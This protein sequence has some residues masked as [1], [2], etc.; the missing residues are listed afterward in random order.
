VTTYT[1]SAGGCAA[2]TTT[3]TESCNRNTDGTTCAATTCGG[4]GAC[5][6][7]STCANDGTQQRTCQQFQC[8]AG[9]CQQS[10]FTESQ[11]CSR[12]TNGSSCGTT[13]VGAWGPCSYA[14]TCANTGT[15]QRSVTTYTCSAGGCAAVTTTET[16]SCSRNTNGTT[17]AATTC[18]GFGACSYGSTCANDGTQQRTCQQFQCAAGTCQ[19]SSFTESQSCSRNTNGTTCGTTV[20]GGY[21]SCVLNNACD[22]TG[23]QFRTI[24]D[25]VCSGGGCA[26]VNTQQSQQCQGYVF[27]FFTGGP[28][29]QTICEGGGTSFSAS[30]QLNN[31]DAIQ[32]QVSSDGGSQWSNLSNSGVF[33]GVNS[34]TLSISGAPAWLNQYRF[35]PVILSACSPQ[36]V[37]GQAV[38]TVNTKPTSVSASA[39]PTVLCAGAQLN[40]SASASGA[41]SYS[42]SGPNGFS[43]SA[44]NTS[45]IVGIADS[46][47]Y[48]VTASNGCGST[49]ALTT[50]VTVISC[51]PGSCG[52]ANGGSTDGP[53][54]QNLCSAGS[55]SAVSGAGPYSWTCFGTGSAPSAS[56]SSNRSCAATTHTWSV[57]GTCSAGVGAVGH[58]G[59]AT[60]TDSTA[61][62]T[63]SRTYSCNQGTWSGVGTGS[64]DDYE[65]LCEPF[66]YGG[67]TNGGGQYLVY[68]NDGNW[69]CYSYTWS[70]EYG[71]CEDDTHSVFALSGPQNDCYYQRRS[72]QC[73]YGYPG[74]I[75]Q[76]NCFGSLCQ[77]T[78]CGAP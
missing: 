53:P 55:P 26:A 27:S 50:S 44:Q 1:C 23:L 34:T 47:Q 71:T 49:Q 31:G 60:A 70:T 7:G 5:S 76:E 28:S 42:W 14:S 6:Y 13:E 65:A 39:S 69:Y 58:G 59:T 74:S 30:A 45:R 46:G 35:R 38:L 56:C 11:S 51:I 22:A 10:S 40:L 21:G 52:A 67:I 72:G 43:S 37:G 66:F 9:T 57:N 2:V 73:C 15:R 4:Y 63:G 68:G 33:S 29:N 8:A 77:G 20:V 17:C 25:F 54:S 16:E 62:A 32:W 41:S 75:C 24:T 18:G 19:Q 64:C 3:E 36:P 78:Y 12:N 48:V 61:P